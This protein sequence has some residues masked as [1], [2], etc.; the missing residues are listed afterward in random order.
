MTNKYQM[1]I[2]SATKVEYSYILASNAGVD[3]NLKCKFM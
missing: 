1:K 2:C 3:Q